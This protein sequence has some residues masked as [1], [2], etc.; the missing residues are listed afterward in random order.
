MNITN[1][2]NLTLSYTFLILGLV[3]LIAITSVLIDGFDDYRREISKYIYLRHKSIAEN[4]S[5]VPQHPEFI[6]GN[7]NKLILNISLAMSVVGMLYLCFIKSAKAFK[8]YKASLCIYILTLLISSHSM[9]AHC[10]IGTSDNMQ[11]ME[12]VS[13]KTGMPL[14][15]SVD[16]DNAESEEN[17]A[18]EYSQETETVE[19]ICPIASDFGIGRTH[20]FFNSD[21]N[22]YIALQFISESEAQLVL[23][24]GKIITR[25]FKEHVRIYYSFNYKGEYRG[26]F[27]IGVDGTSLTLR[28]R[29]NPSD[30]YVETANYVGAAQASNNSNV[31]SNQ[32]GYNAPAYGSSSSTSQTQRQ[33]TLCNGKGWIVGNSTPVYDM[34]EMYCGECGGYY[35]NSHSHNRCPS[36]QGRGYLNY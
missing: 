26:G 27:S 1:K 34:G 14:T 19:T 21:K 3:T 20:W 9:I 32:S 24:N 4:W 30:K 22:Y 35:P 7:N 29:I 36:C 12:Q 16:S 2:H 5:F 28:Y 8:L 6:H 17:L 23:P 13:G 15:S 25:P 31:Y 10:I 18:S 33:C 11:N